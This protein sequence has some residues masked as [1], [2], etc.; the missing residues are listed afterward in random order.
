MSG[1]QYVN[2]V[3]DNKSM[4]MLIIRPMESLKCVST[5]A[6]RIEGHSICVIGVNKKKH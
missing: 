2:K 6:T 1:D 5:T 3:N 4:S